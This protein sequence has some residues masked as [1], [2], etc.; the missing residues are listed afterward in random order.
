MLSRAGPHAVWVFQQIW[1]RLESGALKPEDLTA[2][3]LDS[4]GLVALFCM[5][6]DLMMHIINFE[7][8]RIDM[9]ANSKAVFK[10]VM[11]SFEGYRKRLN[12][13]PAPADQRPQIPDLRWQAGWTGSAKEMLRF[14]ENLETRTTFA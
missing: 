7:L 6:R 12:P 11:G 8:D 14:T 2:R 10:E 3:S 9:D 1:D 4:R 5:K 13:H